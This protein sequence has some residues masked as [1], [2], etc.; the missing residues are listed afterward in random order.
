MSLSLTNTPPGIEFNISSISGVIGFVSKISLTNRYNLN[1]VWRYP[2]LSNIIFIEP[3]PS[4]IL[5]KGLS[6][7]S[8]EFTINAICGIYNYPQ[9]VSLTINPMKCYVTTFAGSTYNGASSRDGKGILAG[10]NLPS[11]ITS[12]S[13]SNLYVADTYNHTIRKITP[14]GTVT[15]IAGISGISGLEYKMENLFIGTREI[16]LK[17][18]VQ[19]VVSTY[20]YTNGI[21]NNISQIIPPSISPNPWWY[22]T[23]YQGFGD[24]IACSSDGKLL[25]IGENYVPY[26][27]GRVLVYSKQNAWFN[28]SSINDQVDRNSAFGLSM[29]I[30]PDGNTLYV[31]YEDYHYVNVFSYINGSWSFNYLISLPQSLYEE[32]QNPI[33]GRSIAISPN[34]LNLFIS[35]VG[36]NNEDGIIQIYTKL[37]EEWNTTS[38]IICPVEIQGIYGHFGKSIAISP[39][40]STLY[41]AGGNNVYIY[42]YSNGVWSTSSY[43]QC[44]DSLLAYGGYGGYGGYSSSFGNSLAISP[45]GSILLIGAPGVNNADGIIQIYTYVNESWTTT[46]SSTIICPAQEQGQYIQFGQSMAFTPDSNYLFI[47]CDYN[48]QEEVFIYSYS[49]GSFNNVSKIN[50]PYSVK[51]DTYQKG[52]G[53]ALAISPDGSTLFISSPYFNSYNGIIS[54][55]T[56]HYT[57]NNIYTIKNPDGH[58]YFGYSIACSSDGSTVFIGYDNY[59]TIQIFT[60]SNGSW[61]NSSSITA[62]A[63]II[64]N[65]YFTPRFGCTIACSSNG[66]NVF[67]GAAAANNNDGIV[68][69][70]TYYNNTW[71]NTSN[72]L[73]PVELQGD[74]YAFG[75]VITISPNESNLFIAG[76]QYRDRVDIFSYSHSSWSNTSTITCPEYL[77]GE[78]GVAFGQSIAIS[79]DGSN[80]LIGAPNFN[81]NDGIVQMYSYLDGSWNTTKTSHILC[82]SEWRGNYARFGSSISLIPYNTTILPANCASLNYPYGITYSPYDNALYVADTY[83]NTIRKIYKNTYN[84]Y[85]PYLIT[86]IAAGQATLNI[87]SNVVYY[88]S[89]IAGNYWYANY[90]GDNVL[91][92][93]A[94]F[95][96]PSAI[97]LDS[98]G[99]IYIADTQ[100]QRIRKITVSTGIITTVA[101]TGSWDYYGDGGAATAAAFRYPFGVAVDSSG[102]IYIADTINNSIRKVTAST[103]I[104]TTV[105]GGNSL[106]GGYYGDGG[107]AIYAGLGYPRG[108]A[109]DTSGN[110]YIADT[111][112]QVIRKVTVSTGI[113]TTIAG[114]GYSDYY[115]DGGPA[116]AAAFRY[117]NA[118]ALDSDSNIYIADTDNH[119]IRKV[120]ISTGIIT[121]IAGNG[122]YGYLGDGGLATDAVITNVYNIAV[123]SDRNIYIADTDNNLIRKVTAS[124]GIITTIAGNG[125]DLPQYQDPPDDFAKNF[126]LTVPTGIAINSSNE[127]YVSENTVHVIFKLSLTDS[128]KKY[129]YTSISGSDDAAIGSNATFHYPFG[130]TASADGYI[131]I[132]DS[133]NNTIRQIDITT[134]NYP[135]TTIAGNALDAP[136]ST[137]ANIGINAR[138]NIPSGITINGSNLYVTD[139]ENNT[140][141]KIGIDETD[142]WPVTTF[143]G[144]AEE[145]GNSNG[146]GTAARFDYPIGITTDGNDFLYVVDAYNDTIRQIFLPSRD[147]FTYAGIPSASNFADGYG[148][149]AQF[150]T[151]SGIVYNNK[152]VFVADTMNSVIRQLDLLYINNP[153]NITMYT[154][155]DYGYYILTIVNPNNIL[156]NL[157]FNSTLSGI[158][159]IEQNGN[160]VITIP[161]GISGYYDVTLYKNI[162]YNTQFNSSYQMKI[163]AISSKQYF[164]STVAGNGYYGYYGD[165]TLAINVGIQ[166]PYGVAV[167]SIGNIYIADT[168]GGRIRKVTASTGII[169]TIAGTGSWDYYGDGGAATAAAFRYPKGIAVDSFDNIYIADTENHRIRKVSAST[170]II[171]TVAGGNG[172]G[173]Y[174]G[175]G[176]LATDA[177]LSYPRGVAIDSV[178]NIYIAD[179]SNQRVRKVTIS[180]GIITTVAGNGNYGYS[181]DDGI[182]TDAILRSPY[183]IAIDSA[184]NIYIADS[185]NQRIRKVTVSTGIITTVAG[186]GNYGY[187]GDG[188]LATAASTAHIYGII[189]DSNG[190]IYFGD[191][192]NRR[193]RK[194]T[195]STGIITTIAGNGNY[196][197][198]GDS[199]VATDANFKLIVGIAFDSAGN[200]YIADEESKRIRKCILYQF[201]QT[202][203]SQIYNASL[204]T[205]YKSLLIDNLLN[206]G[207]SYTFTYNSGSDTGGISID[208]SSTNQAVVLKIEQGIQK[209][210]NLRLT[211]TAKNGIDGH[212]STKI[213]LNYAPFAAVSTIVDAVALNLGLQFIISICIDPSN[214][215]L[216]FTAAAGYGPGNIYKYSLIDNT[217]TVLCYTSWFAIYLCINPNGTELYSIGYGSS[218]IYRISTSTGNITTFNSTYSGLGN[219]PQGLSIDSTGNYLYLMESSSGDVYRLTISNDTISLIQS[220]NYGNRGIFTIDSTNNYLYI[221]QSYSNYNNNINTY[222]LYIYKL[223]L[224]TGN[225]DTLYN[226]SSI[227]ASVAIPTLRGNYLYIPSSSYNNNLSIA[228]WYKFNI[229]TNTFSE[230]IPTSGTI[231]TPYNGVFNNDGSILYYTK[232]FN[233]PSVD[234]I[235]FS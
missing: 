104:I 170:G 110:I 2:L 188:G 76:S 147:V 125:Y 196:G 155:G 103:G 80:L 172:G 70:Y 23:P 124:T 163:N 216:Y 194:I 48:Y 15:T 105:A 145:S 121:T 234:K 120:T 177:T 24:C 198:A 223:N 59:H 187:S 205:L 167:D 85:N 72:I 159:Y 235:V 185:E 47:G 65:A 199:G 180:T 189:L 197:Y 203:Y 222:Y 128:I 207:L 127:I 93:Y 20:S 62:P 191:V 210:Y 17:N 219:N 226:T 27:T 183:G 178:G 138:F 74:Y 100:N 8:T 41:I 54:L 117:P 82:P 157:T 84:Q 79:S 83:N 58:D 26:I 171:T 25:F 31:G 42:T 34:G 86:T 5:V 29:I 204:G 233:G 89:K 22:G 16:S 218:S 111:N 126:R 21:V 32:Y 57:W 13:A 211:A 148:S 150:N 28:S 225:L 46:S 113:I 94:S 214:T 139:S 53:N 158:S 49:N 137:D 67:I 227:E 182:A 19:G 176:G 129:T 228:H 133:Y 134:S 75:S 61:I 141:R 136:G 149:N 52:F 10:F 116:T 39:D 131:Y 51:N 35:A 78:Y 87:T 114:N 98:D 229:L 165:N 231:K 175:D 209:S 122:N 107:L 6:F 156:Y 112:N 73:C 3:T 66:S 168:Y 220:V 11:G 18:N 153:G 38:T 12:D 109:I 37:N 7:I 212:L 215:Y 50:C 106:N 63:E 71:N 60:Y 36:Y 152:S 166:S 77:M 202:N 192:E 97:A 118:I 33:F 102:N 221:T 69:L 200:I 130:I 101:G 184:G 232:V 92:T 164:M 146:I 195:V 201:N 56:I 68:E 1:L 123:D 193:I 186:T 4:S 224:S 115:G 154:Y 88:A 119:V 14:D 30:S 95:N 40:G 181:G 99:N 45:D 64:G 55:F 91:A 169:T 143:A 81:N 132:A 190:N 108:V 90:Y 151:P 96:D 208:S 174:Y 217:L 179:T 44:P 142:L 9:T 162:L 230:I 160:S 213:L 161:H 43:I 144:S 206:I 135:V 140:I 173:G